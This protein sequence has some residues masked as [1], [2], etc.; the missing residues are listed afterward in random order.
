MS[1]KVPKD[2]KP[3]YLDYLIWFMD[4]LNHPPNLKIEISHDTELWDS[5]HHVLLLSS[6][7]KHLETNA[8]VLFLLLWFKFQSDKTRE[9]PYIRIT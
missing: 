4:K 7:S 9:K 5:H 3:L 6:Y 1:S 2:S 8:K